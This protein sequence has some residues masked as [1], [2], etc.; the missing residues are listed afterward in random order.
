MRR[1]LL[2]A[3][4]TALALSLVALVAAPGA[5]A[6]GGAASKLFLSQVTAIKPALP[7]VTVVVLGRGVAVNLHSPAR[8]LNTDRYAK[9]AL[10]TSADAKLAPE[11][12]ILTLGK[13]RSWHDQRIHWMSTIPPPAAKE[14]PE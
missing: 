9:V 5:L 4:L 10:P 12:D 8:Y 6:H 3:A 11:W 13:R 1:R 14:A 7:G 2:P